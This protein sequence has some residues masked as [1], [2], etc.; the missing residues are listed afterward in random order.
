MVLEFDEIVSIEDN[1]IQDFYDIE[2]P[3]THCY[4]AQNILHHN[5]GKDRTIAK[6]FAYILVK[7]L[8]LKNPQEGL[9][10]F[11]G[12]GLGED[13]P[14]DVINVSKDGIQAKRVFFKN[15]QIVMKKITNPET[16]RNYFEE[17]GVDLRDTKDFQATQILLPHNITCH[18][19]NSKEYTGEGLTT[20]FAVV[21]ELGSFPIYSKADNQLT[22][23]R[24]TIASRFPKIGKLCL[25]SFKYE[26]NCPMTIEYKIG[27]KDP[28][29]FS[30][31]H[32]TWEVNITKTKKNFSRQF[33][34]NPDK[35]KMTYTCEETEGLGGYIRNAK[36]ITRCLAKTENPLK[37]DIVSTSRIN[38]LEFKKW[39][40]GQIGKTY[41]LH[42]D[43]AKGK[44]DGDAAGLVMTHPEMM[45]PEIDDS[46]KKELK[47]MGI[48][49]KE[50][51]EVRKGV[52]C[53]LALQLT[54]PPGGELILSHVRKFIFYLK[55][56]LNFNIKFATYD[57]WQSLDSI[58]QLEAMG[59]SAFEL[60][61]D[62]DEKPY[63]S[64]KE[65]I[66]QGLLKGYPHPILNR[67]LKEL[68][69]TEKGKI[70]HPDKSYERYETEGKDNG[71]KDVSD[72]LAGSSI[73]SMEKISTKAGFSFG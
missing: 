22:S 39:F 28:R 44:D 32:A 62:K 3:E 9:N 4:F 16:G 57:R 64:L 13:A 18:S 55:T 47:E 14:I 61:V 56:K 53:D 46:L 68:I 60:S 8:H 52:V 21:D 48:A 43:L 69:K 2:V 38:D 70:D 51:K 41:T 29:V 54:A 12:G 66:Y 23:I 24:G 27:K 33:T 45:F 71:S 6:L 59:I 37:G 67:E 7:L 1:G 58:Q 15:L 34:R 36:A 17:Q 63:L 20:F 5:S 73:V 11:L 40:V 42:V 31:K 65:L 35:A 26:K 30:S 72:C 49:V 10:Y 25:I 19:L 50:E